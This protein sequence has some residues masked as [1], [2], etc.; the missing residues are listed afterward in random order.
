MK[1]G[2]YNLLRTKFLIDTDAIR[3]WKFIIFL[4]ILA[5]ILIANTHRFEQK[6]F[7]ISDLNTENKEL[8]SKFADTRTELMKLKM[9]STIANK[10]SEVGIFPP[11]TPPMK[12]KVVEKKN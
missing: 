12:I 1:E 11:G 3:H 9:E 8:R 7:N 10:M 2:V 6:L 5:I 4:V